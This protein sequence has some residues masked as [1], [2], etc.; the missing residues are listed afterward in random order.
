MYSIEKLYLR[1]KLRIIKSPSRNSWVP[2]V[3][4]FYWGVVSI[5]GRFQ[6]LKPSWS[7]RQ[8]SPPLPGG[9]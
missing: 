1:V 9:H 8:A 5:S 6:Y 4:I 3:A 2:W 7:W